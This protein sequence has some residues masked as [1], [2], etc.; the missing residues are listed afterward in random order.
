[1]GWVP[2]PPAEVVWARERVTVPMVFFLIGAAAE[3]YLASFGLLFVGFCSVF[4]SLT[5]L[6]I[7]GVLL[8]TVAAALVAIAFAFIIRVR[9]NLLRTA[10]AIVLGLTLGAYALDLGF[11]SPDLGPLAAFLVGFVL[12]FYVPASIGALLA[13]LRPLPSRIPVGTF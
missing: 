8:T 13:L 10:G 1:M 5:C 4:P 3:L 6:V 2:P 9:P 7:S 11:F 12:P